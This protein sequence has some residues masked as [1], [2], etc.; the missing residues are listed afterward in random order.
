MR[1]AWTQCVDISRKHYLKTPGFQVT[2]RAATPYI[3]FT[4]SPRAVEELAEQRRQKRGLQTFTVI[5]PNTRL[6]NGLPILD[7]GAEMEHYDVRNPYGR[8][9][10]YCANHYV[11]L[12]QVT[13]EE[14]IGHWKWDE[15]LESGN[16]YEDIIMPAFRAFSQR[17][18]EKAKGPELSTIMAMLCC[19]PQI[20]ATISQADREVN[21]QQTDTVSHSIEEPYTWNERIAHSSGDDTWIS[22]DK[23]NKRFDFTL[24]DDW[25]TNYEVEEANANDDMIKIIK[26]DW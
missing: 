23:A 21:D 22:D 26:G 3:S 16:W 2:G 9:D 13:E 24:E 7:L 6:R 15:L 1:D 4:S 14:I 12:W 19:K 5:D 18:T 17:S 10:R 8:R 25:D 20:S 11:C